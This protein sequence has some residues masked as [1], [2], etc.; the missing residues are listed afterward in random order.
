MHPRRICIMLDKSYADPTRQIRI[1]CDN[2][3]GGM[4][5]LL[6]GTRWQRMLSWLLARTVRDCWNANHG[7]T[8]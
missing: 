2:S 6:H 7:K 3:G 8:H 4:Q 5:V 1:I